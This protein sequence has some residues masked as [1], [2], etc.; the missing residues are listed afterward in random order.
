MRILDIILGVAAVAALVALPFLIWQWSTYVSRRRV[1]FPSLR[2]QV[3]MPVKAV[4]FFIIPILVA[5]AAAETSKKIAHDRVLERLQALKDDSR[6]LVN[7]KATTNSH[8]ILAILK[9]LDWA[10]AHH[11]SPTKRIT[12]QIS[13]HAPMTLELARDS[14]VPREYWV[15]YPKYYITRINEIGRVT[16]PLFDTY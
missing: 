9:T 7:G 13:E 8:E 3:P 2:D 11:S 14:S 4:L 10:P 1:S 6:I 16:T 12:V 5:G 15:F